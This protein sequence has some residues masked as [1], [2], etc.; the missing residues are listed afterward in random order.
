[1]LSFL[2]GLLRQFAIAR[3]HVPRDDILVVKL[4]VVGLCGSSSCGCFVPRNDTC[5]RIKKPL[6]KFETLTKVSITLEFGSSTSLRVTIH[7]NLEFIPRLRDWD[8][9]FYLYLSFKPTFPKIIGI[10]FSILEILVFSCFAVSIYSK[11]SY[12]L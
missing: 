11:N 3:A 10:T 7:W 1:M 5:L 6:S 4:C 12:C 2:R 8:L 9:N